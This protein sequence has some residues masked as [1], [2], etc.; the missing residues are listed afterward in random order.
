MG[1]SELRGF[2]AQV[3]TS[4]NLRDIDYNRG[5]IFNCVRND[6]IHNRGSINYDDNDDI[7]PRTLSDNYSYPLA[8]NRGI[9]STRVGT[10]HTFKRAAIV[11]RYQRK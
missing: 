8:G 6:D 1:P 2:I 9:E 4:A 11:Y 10:R 3:A 5:S 7:S